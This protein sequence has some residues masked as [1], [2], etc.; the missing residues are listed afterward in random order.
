MLVEGFKVNKSRTLFVLVFSLVN[1]FI[2]YVFGLFGVN[3]IDPQSRKILSYSAIVVL[4]ISV[5]NFLLDNGHQYH[6]SAGGISALIVVF[7]LWNNN[8]TNQF[9]ISQ[10]FVLVIV[11]WFMILD[12]ATERSL[13]GIIGNSF[14]EKISI[15]RGSWWSSLFIQS[16]I[17][18]SVVTL[19]FFIRIHDIGGL[20]PYPDEYSHLIAARGMVA[21]NTLPE[22][23][24]S[25][26]I[27]TFPVY[28]L[29]E[30][31]EPSVQIARV[32]P[33]VFSSITIVPL[34]IILRQINI[35]TAILGILLY[36]TNPWVIGIGRTVREY[37]VF[38]F[39]SAILFLLLYALVNKFPEQYR[40]TEIK[41]IIR[42]DQTIPVLLLTLS[43]PILYIILV[44]SMLNW[45]SSAMTVLFLYPAAY[46]CFILRS[47]LSHYKTKKTFV[48]L[49]S[50]GIVL[51]LISIHIV[52]NLSTI[53]SYSKVPFNLF[54]SNSDQQWFSQ[55][56]QSLIVAFLLLSIIYALSSKKVILQL[57]SMTFTFEFYIFGFHF[58]RYYRP[59]YGFFI[60]LWYIA[61]VTI[62][63]LSAVELV[64][65]VIKKLTDVDWSATRSTAVD[66]GLVLMILLA[67][68]NPAQTLL[69]VNLHNEYN[70]TYVPITH[71]YHPDVEK[72]LEPIKDHSQNAD[73]IIIDG[74]NYL[75]WTYPEVY[76]NNIV[77]QH[78]CG[79]KKGFA[80]TIKEKNDNI[81]IA[82][83]HRASSP[84]CISEEW[85]EFEKMSQKGVYHIY[86]N[87]HE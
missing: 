39:Y 40:V 52:P 46:I 73:V 13:F 81:L 58:G 87:Y 68:V 49:T 34:Y 60:Q 85:G 47:D 19:A 38:P 86:S 79:S 15:D 77:Y 84:T 83:K 4:S 30:L 54:I 26:F 37:A 64:K 10:L 76:N 3:V 7:T 14:E 72:D 24:R 75:E 80:D 67:F 63:I 21:E 29:F 62:G 16:C 9:K 45:S 82:T 78:V 74:A 50:L 48:L 11:S 27:V 25:F 55:T 8:L 43:V 71:E 41:D 12:F 6:A 2:F 69:A 35:R 33:V 28:L 17:V 23:T 5:Y 65:S 22:Y 31:L 32:V 44:E 66:I 59:R 57:L 53:P 20:P 51:G 61:I 36:C 56:N 18:L 70:G 42:E 1:T